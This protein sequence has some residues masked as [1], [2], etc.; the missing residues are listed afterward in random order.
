MRVY[1]G[2]R[3]N[4]RGG[5]NKQTI[6]RGRNIYKNYGGCEMVREGERVGRQDRYSLVRRII[7]VR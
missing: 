2:R 1:M 4:S 6:S 7:Q 3:L 5:G